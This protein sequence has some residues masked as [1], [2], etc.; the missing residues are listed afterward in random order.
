MIGEVLVKVGIMEF[1][2]YAFTAGEKLSLCEAVDADLISVEAAR[3]LLT[4]IDQ[5]SLNNSNIDLST[6][7][8]V[9]PDSGQSMPLQV[10]GHFRYD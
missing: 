6:G 2:L 1:G 10:L 4:A 5:N 9:D 7:E 8:Y 3:L